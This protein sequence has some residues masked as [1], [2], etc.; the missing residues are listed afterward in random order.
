M[1]VSAPD[2]TLTVDQELELAIY[3]LAYGGEG[4]A[5]HQGM[6]VFIAGSLPGDRVRVRVTQVKK[7]FARAEL[8]CIVK[9]SPERVDPFCDAASMCGGCSW[10]YLAYPGQLK[11][12]QAFVENALQHVGHLKGVAVLPTIKAVPQTGYRH[13]IQIPFQDNGQGLVT[14]F[15]ARQTHRVVPIEECPVQPGLGNRLFRAVRELAQAH[16]LRGYDEAR[17]QG[18]LRHLTIRVGLNT[19]EVLALLVTTRSKIPA[20]TDL[21]QALGQRLPE[22][23]GVV[24]NV[25]SEATNVVLGQE[26]KVLT[27]RPYLFEEIEGIRYRISAQSFFQV[28][29][30]QLP[31]LSEAVVQAAG[32]SGRETVVDLFCGVGFLTLQLA[33]RARM[34]FGVESVPAAVED[35]LAT[36]HLHD[37]SNVEFLTADVT[38]GL[39]A[40]AGKGLHPDAVVLDPPRKGCE[41]AL[42]DH[43]LRLKPGRVVY[44]SCNPTTLARDLACLTGG[45]YSVQQVQPLDLF[46]HTYHVESVATLVRKNNH[47]S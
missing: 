28:N 20:L 47:K 22:L 29:P 45:G 3:A 32:L 23:V 39:R 17:N 38:Q 15:Y 46:P 9:P 18:D 27:G 35:A 41:P 31:A 10:Q 6:V 43:L 44:I 37:Y 19:K 36:K 7:R 42:L 16:G 8:I 26:F 14:G 21:A 34:A 40:L 30:H 33:K 11:A 25:N 13:K 24:Q 1:T 2:S 4:I 12:K 5:K